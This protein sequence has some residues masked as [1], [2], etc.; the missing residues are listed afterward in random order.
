MV[1]T[2]WRRLALW[3]SV[4]GRMVLRTGQRWCPTAKMV[5][6]GAAVMHRSSQRCGGV[7]RSGERGGVARHGRA[8]GR[9]VDSQ[10]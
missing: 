2:K 5:N 10:K 4:D 1:V 8:G 6:E 9:A 3:V 7:Q